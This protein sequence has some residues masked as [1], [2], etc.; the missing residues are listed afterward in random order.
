M[1][2]VM[3]TVIGPVGSDIS[4]GDPPNKAANRPTRIA[5]YKPASAP[6]PDATPNASAMGSAMIAAVTP[7]KRSPLTLPK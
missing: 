7:P 6:A 2:A 4:A 5:P 3:T 1:T